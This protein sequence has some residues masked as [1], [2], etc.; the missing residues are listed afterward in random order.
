M[1]ARMNIVPRP[2][3]I[4]LVWSPFLFLWGLLL[5]G[6]ML[7]LV[8]LPV[9]ALPVDGLYSF[10]LTVQNQSDA[11]RRRAYREALAG[12][13]LKVTGESR[14]VQQPQL[15]SA[16]NNAQSY[17]EEVS[18][19]SGVRPQ[20]ADPQQNSD[21]LAEQPVV[22]VPAT[23]INVRFS[24]D[25]IDDLLD[26]ANI[27]IWDRNRPSVL[28]WLSIENA[29]S[30]RMLLGSDSEHQVMEIIREFSQRRGVPLL[31]PVLDFT[32]RR[33]LSADQA[34]SLDEQAI[35]AASARYGADSIL[36]GRLLVT[37][38][39][40]LVGMWQFI[41]NDSIATFDGFENDLQRYMETSLDR[42]TA[43]LAA[44]FSIVRSTLQ[45][46]DSV[47]LRVDGIRSIAA[48]QSVV[49]YVS[50][51]AVV[52]NVALS[53]LSEDSL[54]LKVTLSGSRTHLA[55]FMNLDRDLE[56]VEPDIRDENNN[57][58]HYRWTR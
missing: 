23:F 7:L 39:G 41:F 22:S 27:P 33:N 15:Q 35:L 44:Q 13:L 54:E 10:E 8:S 17:V 3:E 50:D 16:L 12:V 42:V 52:R 48:H 43:S 20:L 56:A 24:R 32:D 45:G 4:P 34:W 30:E 9:V 28:V 26:S 40:E 31:I 14:W 1:M 29:S 51:L 49:S 2:L 36:S 47:V 57:F 58:L 55:E 18:F 25:L 11:E 46:N 53:R 5:S 19:R 6:L 38:A 21:L 37:P